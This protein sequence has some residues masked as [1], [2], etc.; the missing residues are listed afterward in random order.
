M[1]SGE[2]PREIS[3]LSQFDPYDDGRGCDVQKELSGHVF[4]RKPTGL[5]EQ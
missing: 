4:R 2:E 5:N 3:I 1:P